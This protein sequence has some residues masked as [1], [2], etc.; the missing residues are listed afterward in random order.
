MVF[1]TAGLAVS[2]NGHGSGRVG[3]SDAGFEVVLCLLERFMADA[4][5]KIIAT[6]SPIIVEKSS[7]V[8]CFNSMCVLR[9]LFLLFCESCPLRRVNSRRL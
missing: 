5:L 9:S 3:S 4:A 7:V 8:S 1:S 2:N 6:A